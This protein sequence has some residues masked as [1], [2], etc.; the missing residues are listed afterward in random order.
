[1]LCYFAKPIKVTTT[2]KIHHRRFRNWLTHITRPENIR[3]A[4]RQHIFNPDET[5]LKKSLSVGFGI[6]M[7]I[8]PIW[9]FQTISAILL[10]GLFRL[11]KALT[12]IASHISMPPLIAL[13]IYCSLQT[14]KLWVGGKTQVALTKHLSKNM[15]GKDLQQYLLGSMTLAIAAGLAAFACTWCA[16]QVLELARRNRES[17]QPRATPQPAIAT[18]E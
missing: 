4:I 13:V 5:I 7:G 15:I 2:I 18:A 9:G 8:V 16:L 1:M 6:F 11:N 10:A 12:L 3:A 17:G 14:G